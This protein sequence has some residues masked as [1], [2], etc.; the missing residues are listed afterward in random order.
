MAADEMTVKYGIQ[1][2][3]TLFVTKEGRIPKQD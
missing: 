3:K 2:K 1:S